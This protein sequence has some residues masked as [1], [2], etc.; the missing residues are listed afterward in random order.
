LFYCSTALF[1][2]RLKVDV[3]TYDLVVYF[4]DVNGGKKVTRL[5]S[6][7]SQ[8]KVRKLNCWGFCEVLFISKMFSEKRLQ[9]F[10]CYD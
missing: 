7:G 4:H 6:M 1:S 5:V 10:G 2:E 8:G 9:R 3:E